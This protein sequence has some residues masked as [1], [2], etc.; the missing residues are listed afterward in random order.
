M[1]GTESNGSKHQELVA[2]KRVER[3]L[4]ICEDYREYGAVATPD[5]CSK[6]WVDNLV[7]LAQGHWKLQLGWLHKTKESGFG[8]LNWG[9]CR[10]HLLLVFCMCDPT[11]PVPAWQPLC[12]ASLHATIAVQGW[13]MGNFSLTCTFAISMY[14]RGSEKHFCACFDC[15]N[16]L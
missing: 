7:D 15:N 4:F 12:C 3:F 11:A 16:M 13:I 5:A 10:K 6:P 9:W 1:V 8:Q 14:G 2:W